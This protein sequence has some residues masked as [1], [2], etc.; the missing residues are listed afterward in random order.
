VL[1]TDPPSAP[2]RASPVV[3]PNQTVL[4]TFAVAKGPAF[5]QGE[6]VGFSV[7]G[8]GTLSRSTSTTDLNGEVQ[9][10]YTEPGSGG[11][12][13]TVRADVSDGTVT[14]RAS[15]DVRVQ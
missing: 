10:A 5:A 14:G 4:I 6:A 13:A 11:L 12:T 2:L 9:V 3:A 8:A 1:D 7:V 15:I